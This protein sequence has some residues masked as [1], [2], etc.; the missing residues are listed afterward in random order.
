MGGCAYPTWLHVFDTLESWLT[1]FD[2]RS[3]KQ[4]PR[5]TTGDPLGGGDGDEGGSM[6]RSNPASIQ[7]RWE[8][9]GTP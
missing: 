4:A 6:G 5:M 2:D 8:A 9:Q 1:L 3:P 7:S